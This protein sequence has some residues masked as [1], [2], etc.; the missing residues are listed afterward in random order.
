MVKTGPAGRRS[1]SRRV[2]EASL[3]R[4]TLVVLVLAAAV[5]VVLA[6]RLRGR[7]TA[8]TADR[9]AH[10]VIEQLFGPWRPTL[11]LVVSLGDAPVV[12]AAAV[13]LFLV[14]LARRRIALAALALCGPFAT[15][16]ATTALQPMVGRTLDGGNALPSGHAGGV[17]SVAAVVAL[18]AVTDSARPRLAGGLALVGTLVLS[19]IIAVALVVNDEHYWTDTVAGSCTALVVVLG[20]ALLIDAVQLSQRHTPPAEATG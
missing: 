5:L 6:V 19:E 4:P 7:T 17:T 13:L 9:V 11:R 20:F 3:V 16:I 1:R 15:G 10:G 8:A 12:L 18:I 14:C 2:V